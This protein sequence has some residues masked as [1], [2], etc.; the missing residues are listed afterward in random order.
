MTMAFC[1]LRVVGAVVLLGDG[2]FAFGPGEISLVQRE[3]G[4]AAGGQRDGTGV[5]DEAAGVRDGPA[6]FLPAAQRLEG[7]GA[8]AQHPVWCCP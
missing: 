5:L 3:I 1:G 7:F 2:E 4:A 8:V 6:R